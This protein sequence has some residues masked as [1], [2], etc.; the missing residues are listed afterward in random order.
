MD[1]SVGLKGFLLLAAIFHTMPKHPAQKEIYIVAPSSISIHR[2]RRPVI[3]PQLSC[4]EQLLTRRTSLTVFPLLRQHTPNSKNVL[5]LNLDP[6]CLMLV[7]QMVIRPAVVGFHRCPFA[8]D[9]IV[10]VE[11]RVVEVLEEGFGGMRHFL[12]ERWV[13]ERGWQAVAGGEGYVVSNG[14]FDVA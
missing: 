11:A 12:D 1:R 4:P 2:H 3:S 14:H 6:V 8:M 9:G 13:G 7:R 10:H 5:L